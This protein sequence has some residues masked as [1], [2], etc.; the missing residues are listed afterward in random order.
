M[1]FAFHS[2]ILRR[3]FSNKLI[4]FLFICLFLAYQVNLAFGKVD[5]TD[6]IPSGNIEVPQAT[7]NDLKK[8]FTEVINDNAKNSNYQNSDTNPN[9][10]NILIG[11]ITVIIVATSGLTFFQHTSF[12]RY[13]KQEL[14]AFKRSIEAEQEIMKNSMKGFIRHLKLK[15]ILMNDPEPT[16]DEIYEYLAY[17]KEDPYPDYK[18]T[19]AKIMKMNF[20]KEIKKMAEEGLQKLENRKGV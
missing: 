17:I 18:P 8:M 20:N 16:G 7:M 3:K 5:K 14:K 11:L 13:Y 10:V 15:T 19:F 2:K 4:I 12:N 6:S 9:T 1:T